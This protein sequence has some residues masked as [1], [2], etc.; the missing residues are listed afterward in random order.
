MTRTAV[1]VSQAAPADWARTLVQRARAPHPVLR[2]SSWRLQRRR[3]PGGAVVRQD[4]G[5]P[6]WALPDLGRRRGRRAS[7]AGHV[8]HLRTPPLCGVRRGGVDSHGSLARDGGAARRAHRRRRPAQHALLRPVGRRT[9]A[10]PPGDP[11]RRRPR[12]A[13]PGQSTTSARP[14]G[15]RHRHGHQRH[16]LGTSVGSSKRPSRPTSTCGTRHCASVSS[17]PSRPRRRSA[18]SCWPAC[19][20]DSSG[21]SCTG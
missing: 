16:A 15:R 2:R 11:L 4:G 1:D 8:R 18:R 13:R 6:P 7:G 17:A 12:A 19:P 21:S 10:G 3:L 5:S 20:T 9:G 14:P